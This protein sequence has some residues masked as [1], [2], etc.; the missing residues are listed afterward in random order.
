[1]RIKETF[2]DKLFST[3]AYLM[4][5]LIV[6]LFVWIVLIPLYK[7]EKTHAA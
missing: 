7:K 3:F 5:A 1:M 4:V 2:Q 6:L